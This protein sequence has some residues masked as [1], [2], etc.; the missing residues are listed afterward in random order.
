MKSYKTITSGVLFVVLIIAL[1]SSMN[2]R[3]GTASAGSSQ[4]HATGNC[5]VSAVFDCGTTPTCEDGERTDA[6]EYLSGTDPDTSSSIC[7]NN[8]VEREDEATDTGEK[9][10]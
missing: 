4:A 1:T 8:G 7:I 10:A 6:Y 2:A 3:A 5:K 9:E